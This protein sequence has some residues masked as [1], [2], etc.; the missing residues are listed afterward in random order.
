MQGFL[1]WIRMQG[2]LEKYLT[3]SGIMTLDQIKQ[4]RE[5][6][7]VDLLVSDTLI[8]EEENGKI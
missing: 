7:V 5:N 4:L 3:E 2:G 1:E 6:L 8:D